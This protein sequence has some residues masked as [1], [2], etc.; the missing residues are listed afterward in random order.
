VL[1]TIYTRKPRQVFAGTDLNGFWLEYPGSKNE[2]WTT[3][4]GG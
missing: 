4:A 2:Q 1:P 3:P